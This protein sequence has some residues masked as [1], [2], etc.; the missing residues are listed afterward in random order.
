MNSSIS[1]DYENIW[2]TTR[3]WYQILQLIF[4][5]G[6][7]ILDELL[8]SHIFYRSCK[9][10]ESLGK[11]MNKEVFNVYDDLENPQGMF[12]L[13]KF[14][15]C[16]QSQKWVNRRLY[17]SCRIPLKDISEYLNDLC[18]TSFLERIK[19][20]PHLLYS[21]ILQGQCMMQH[22]LKGHTIESLE[23]MNTRNHEHM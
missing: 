19:H 20:A 22:V 10:Y 2:I 12:L 4:S 16:K 15:L 17:L 8:L 23:T 11:K 14:L 18:N 13:C 21:Q 3:Y 1:F 5:I 9:T 7:T 6:T